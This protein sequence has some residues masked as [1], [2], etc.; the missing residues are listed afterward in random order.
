MELGPRF[1]CVWS[2]VQFRL[3]SSP[4][5]LRGAP[6]GEVFLRK[7]WPLPR[8][9]RVVSWLRASFFS[10]FPK[11][12]WNCFLS[13]L[14]RGKAEVARADAPKFDGGAGPSSNYEEKALL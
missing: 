10:S 5:L 13:S 7:V 4:G 2:A 1:L 14:R 6:L 11:P 8:V 9:L 12:V 3:C